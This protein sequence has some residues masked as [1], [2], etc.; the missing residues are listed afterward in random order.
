MIR[1]STELGL[2]Y[3]GNCRLLLGLTILSLLV[4]LR[5]SRGS[6]TR[7]H[8]GVRFP[9]HVF[10]MLFA[11]LFSGTVSDRFADT[12]FRC[13]ALQRSAARRAVS[14]GEAM[15]FRPGRAHV[16]AD[17]SRPP[18]VVRAGLVL[19]T[20]ARSAARGW[21]G[22]SAAQGRALALGGACPWPAASRHTHSSRLRLYSISNRAT[23]LLLCCGCS[24]VPRAA[25]SLY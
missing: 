15:R 24:Q 9:M 22:R 21:P 12:T 18:E 7:Y 20:Q 25:V 17:L 4:C 1:R 13:A 2:F 8:R 11:S 23:V 5:S 3:A 6:A 14:S 19:A 16:A 10:S